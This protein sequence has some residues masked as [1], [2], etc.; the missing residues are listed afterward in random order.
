MF[1]I[2]FNDLFI[3]KIDKSNI[4]LI[5]IC[6]ANSNRVYDR[7]NYNFDFSQNM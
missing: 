5:I 1:I 7:Y 6:V 3:K 2:D 4:R